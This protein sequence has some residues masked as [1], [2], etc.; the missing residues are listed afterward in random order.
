MGEPT[1]A[2][3]LYFDGAFAHARFG[4]AHTHDTH[5]LLGTHAHTHMRARFVYTQ[6]R[7]FTL[8]TKGCWPSLS[9]SASRGAVVRVRGVRRGRFCTHSAPP[10]PASARFFIICLVHARQLAA[11][12]G[13]QA[14][15]LFAVA[16]AAVAARA[17]LAPLFPLQTTLPLTLVL[18]RPLLDPAPSPAPFVALL[19][20]RTLF[21]RTLLRCA[22][23]AA[24]AAHPN[25]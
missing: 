25:N 2:W 3:R 24:R 13:G 18:F 8:G 10:P 15:A 21:A 20:C 5:A 23:R 1:A 12:A 6:P 22:W 19:Q 16:A 17:R 14:P 9:L 7:S 11:A 4:R